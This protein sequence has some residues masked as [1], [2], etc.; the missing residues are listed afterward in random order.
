MKTLLI[1]A[2]IAGLVAVPLARAGEQPSTTD[3]TSPQQS[4]SSQTTAPS[5][6]TPSQTG[7]TATASKDLSGT[8]KK[9]DQGKRSL[10]ISSAAGGEQEVKVAEGAKIVTSDGAQASLGE[11]KEGDQ[12]RA[13]FDSSSDQASQIEVSSK[14]KVKADE[15]S[16]TMPE[17]K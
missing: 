5:Q 11:I 6:A 8:V 10:K 2:A 3:K 17:Q 12:V 9:V 14:Q 4:S 7:V 16:K 15:K 13:S 1:G